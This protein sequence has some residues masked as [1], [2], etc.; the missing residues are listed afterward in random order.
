MD[1]LAAEGHTANLADLHQDD[2]HSLELT[3]SRG[4]RPRRQF[5]DQHLDHAAVARAHSVSDSTRHVQQ[6]ASVALL[7]RDGSGESSRTRRPGFERRLGSGSSSTHHRDLEVAEHIINWIC[8]RDAAA[9]RVQQTNR[10][11]IRR[12]VLDHH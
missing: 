8:D 2:R 10:T 6:L 11:R 1:L 3:R 9:A 5:L 12:H 7:N 4:L